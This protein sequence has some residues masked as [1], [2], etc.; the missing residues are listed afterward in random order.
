MTT[1]K[2]KSQFRF[3]LST[4]TWISSMLIMRLSMILMMDFSAKVS[5]LFASFYSHFFFISYFT[6]FMIGLIF[7]A[8]STSISSSSYLRD[9][10]TYN[11]CTVTVVGFSFKLAQGTLTSIFEIWLYLSKTGSPSE[12]MNYGR[13]DIF[14]MVA[15][16]VMLI[17]IL[18]LMPSTYLPRNLVSTD[19][20]MLENIAIISNLSNPVNY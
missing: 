12:L 15:F 4:R 1:P 2:E 6:R 3:I 19:S 11:P 16:P 14:Y 13:S 7:F 9:S 10:K 18:F 5:V 20:M 17:S 8:G